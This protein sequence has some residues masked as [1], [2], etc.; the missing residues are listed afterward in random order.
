MSSRIF[1]INLVVVLAIAALFSGFWALYNLP[2]SAPDWPD[3]IAGYSFSPFREGQT[4]QNNIYPSDKEIT[5][6]LEMLAKQT[7]N[8]RTYSVDEA[9]AHIPRLAEEFGLRVTLGVWISNDEERNER[10]IAKAIELANT[11]RS[12]VRVLVGNE[13]LFRRE[14]TT[15]K[16]IGYLDRVR[17]GVK[18]PVST[19]EQWH[20]WEESPELAQHVDLIAAHVLPY[21]EFIPMEDSTQFVLD[22]ARDLKKLFPKK[23]LLLSEVGWPSNGRMRGGADA[24]QADQAIYLR[25]LV[26]TLNA[27]GYNYFV[28]EAFDQTWKISDE[29]SVGAYWG[30]YNL[31][32]QPKFNFTGPVVAIPQWR[33]LAIGSVVMA[34]LSLALLL[35]DGS[36][37]RQRG[38]TFLTFVAFAGGSALVWIGYDYSQ[39]YSTWFSL[40][41]GIL[42]GI[43]AIGVF[44]VLLTEAHELA[45]AAWVRARRRPF[46]PVMGDSE[47]RPKVSIHVPCYNEPP[48]MVKQ[49]LDALANLD[50]PDYEVIIIDNNTKDPA[51]WEPVQAYCEQLGPRFRFFH[52]APIAG[53]KGG[54][55]NYILPFTAPDVEVIAVID[56]D[57]CVDPNWLKHMVP[58]FADP[59]IAVVQSP[60]DYRDGNTSTFKKLCYAEYKGFFHIGMV[61]RNDRN[62]IIQ[63]GTMTMIRRTVMDELKWADWTICEDAELGLRVFKK[64]YSA[65]YAH[66]SFGKGLMPDT[67]IDYKKQRFRWAYGAIQIM[68]GHARSLFLGKD[69]SLKR[70]QRYHFIAGWLPWVADGLNIFF[71]VGALLW[72]AAMIIVPQRVDPPLLIFAIPPLALFVFKLGKIVFLYQRAVGVNL[73]DAFCAAVAGLALSHTIAKAVLYGL[74]TTTIPFF[75][76]PKMRS[77][78]GFLVA[79][80]E[81]REEVFIMLLLWGAVVGI[82]IAQG[83]PSADVKFW[84]ATLLVQSLPYLAA[85]I[86]AMLSSLPKPV[87]SEA[88]ID[89]EVVS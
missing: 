66:D 88:E 32:R 48:E 43:G 75:R 15:E 37:L 77:S 80:A 49:T 56:S 63:H 55:L 31:E 7:D 58:H 81:A 85:V 12:V 76:T 47:Y 51:V 73:K 71:T 33:L 57:Y 35:I 46:Q 10:E 29:G 52:K 30:V 44:I 34:L 9:L 74:F 79:L 14:I 18:V 45:E 64:G 4:P 53:F 69:S 1:G 42:L 21:W 36:S 16:L 54:A 25:T 8:I 65:A 40:T 5:Q 28:I 3:R 39:Q 22:R 78:H 26:N 6:D 84:V 82:T 89:A 11:S 72:S 70:G 60:Q 62:A 23:P 17:A 13:A 86:M 41:V 50:Y 67:F 2:V 59:Q 83:L 61:T 68:K 24:S 20:I 38:R 87:E 19:S 27:K